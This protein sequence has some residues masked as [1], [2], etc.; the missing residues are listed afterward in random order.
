MKDFWFGSFHDFQTYLKMLILR[1]TSH[2]TRFLAHPSSFSR[3]W[4]VVQQQP[5]IL[6]SPIKEK[7]LDAQ[8]CSTFREREIPQERFIYLVVDFKHLEI[9]SKK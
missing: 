2:K 7:L 1:R 9:V 4:P 6:T 5:I 3:T 8:I